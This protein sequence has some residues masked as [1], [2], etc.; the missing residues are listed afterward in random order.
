MKS[1]IILNTKNNNKYLYNRKNKSFTLLHPLLLYLIKLDEEGKD[2]EIEIKNIEKNLNIKNC[3]SFPKEEVIYY[4]KKLLF[5][6]SNKLLESFHFEDS[7]K[8]D[9]NEKNTLSFFVNS[10]V[11][12]FEVTQRC[13]L[14]CKYCAYGEN[15]QWFDKRSDIDLNFSKAK[16]LLD[17]YISLN[18]TKYSFAY[19]KELI[20][21]F[22]GGEP[23]LNF[24]FIKQV[25]EYL[26]NLKINN[27]S[28]KFSMTTNALLIHKYCDFI[29]KYNFN[30][31]ISTD[32]NEMNNQYRVYKNNKPA[33]PK[34]YKNIVYLK[35]KYPDYFEESVNFNAVL[36]NKNSV[37]EI[38][39]FF[40]K[41]FGKIA[42]INEITSYG[43]KD[44]KKDDF[45][46]IYTN[47][48]KS[49]KQ[50][51]DYSNIDMKK[52]VNSPDYQ[53]LRD[54]IISNNSYINYSDLLYDFDKNIVMT[55]T[56]SPFSFKIFMT[57][58]GKLLPCENVDHK[59]SLGLVTDDEVK[60]DFKAIAERYSEYYNKMKKQCFNCYFQTHCIQC[61]LFLDI[62]SDMP[63][64]KGYTPNHK[65]YGTYLSTRIN[66]IEKNSDTYLDIMNE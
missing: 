65:E 19:K 45:M 5:L 34:I 17:Y 23:L 60:I 18:N 42:S 6:K 66:M 9:M 62:D 46:K 25:V 48:D 26:T 47:I 51:E 52:A 27:L 55:S 49:L 12:V 16:N 44:D 43:V 40:K 14:K 10:D 39:S 33:Y 53:D 8:T 28:F 7:V 31:L 36:H 54:F 13:N 64:C 57:V 20:V 35:E 32:G 15:Y 50:I 38:Y 63:K 1:N 2:T 29:S 56:C 30:L 22:Y 59:Y 4:Y 3:G 21:G 37:I 41:E 24:K 58:N 61:M 11:I